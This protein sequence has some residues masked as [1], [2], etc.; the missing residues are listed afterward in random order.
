M[1]LVNKKDAGILFPFG[2][3][4]AK[5]YVWVK[6]VIVVAYNTV[7]KQGGIQAHFKWAYLVLLGISQNGIPAHIGFMRQHIINAVVHPVIVPL[8]IGTGCGSALRLF[9]K[10]AQLFFCRDREVLEIKI[11][12]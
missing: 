8:G 5:V 1:G 2:E 7:G 12:F 4:A 9:L 3:K 10:K 11:L 6:C